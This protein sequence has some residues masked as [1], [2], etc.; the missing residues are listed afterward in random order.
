MHSNIIYSLGF[1]L[2]LSWRI[3]DHSVVHV[4]FPL[5]LAQCDLGG[6]S[7]HLKTV[8][9]FPQK[10]FFF[11]PP[12]VTY[13]CWASAVLD[14]DFS[15]LGMCLRQ[16]YKLLQCQSQQ[17]S[18]CSIREQE[19][20]VAF[21]TRKF[22]APVRRSSKAALLWMR[23]ES[24]AGGWCWQCHLLGFAVLSGK[25]ASGLQQCSCF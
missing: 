25:K 7:D 5:W 20:K 23:A 1:A 16:T 14:R 17:W 4:W 3:W 6:I 2:D 21:P 15:V 13:L 22:L 8:W 10:T 24:S 19:R 9:C 11:L 18:Q 12:P